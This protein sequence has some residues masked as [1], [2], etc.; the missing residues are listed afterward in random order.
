MHERITHGVCALSGWHRLQPMAGTLS[1]G[2]CA[3]G[4]KLWPITTS[5]SQGLTQFDN[6]YV[7]LESKVWQWNW[8]STRSFMHLRGVFQS[9]GRNLQYPSSDS[10]RQG[11]YSLGKLRWPIG[12]NINQ[13]MHASTVTCVHTHGDVNVHQKKAASIVAFDHPS[14]FV[15]F[16]FWHRFWPAHN[17]HLMST[18]WHLASV[19]DCIFLNQH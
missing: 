13:F 15:N 16:F 12:E 4:N 7:H 9:V 6:A 19:A 5:I 14:T 2:F 11:L 17:D 8:R 10:V 1:Q 18:H 3:L